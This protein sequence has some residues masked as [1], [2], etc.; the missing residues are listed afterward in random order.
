MLIH[1]CCIFSA[2][3]KKE[4]KRDRTRNW[5]VLLRSLEPG[6]VS[7]VKDM[8]GLHNFGRH[9][10]RASIRSTKAA[11]RVVQTTMHFEPDLLTTLE[12]PKMI[13]YNLVICFG[14][15]QDRSC[16]ILR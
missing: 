14:D 8:L 5:N 6:R 2:A 3:R 12:P 9:G 11:D 1:A 15:I 4:E 16:M 13:K 7:I 10:I